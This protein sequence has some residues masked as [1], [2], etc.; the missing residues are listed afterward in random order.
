MLRFPFTAVR[1]TDR[2]RVPSCLTIHAPTRMRPASDSRDEHIC[3]VTI[4]GFEDWDFK[5]YGA[6]SFQAAV[7]AME[8]ARM[9]LATSGWE[10]YFG[11]EGPAF[12][13][14]PDV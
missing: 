1:E 3:R 10:I 6:F 7:L 4:E 2:E 14:W 5:A 13:N 8:T 9:R 11:D 12:L